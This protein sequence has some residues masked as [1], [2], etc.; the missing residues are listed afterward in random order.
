MLNCD[1]L[2]PHLLGSF[3]TVVPFDSIIE[4]KDGT[5][6][7]SMFHRYEIKDYQD[8]NGYLI[9]KCEIIVP[10]TSWKREIS[11]QMFGGRG[12]PY[13][14]KIKNGNFTLT[15]SQ[16][17]QISPRTGAILRYHCHDNYTLTGS[18]ALICDHGSWKLS[19][20]KSLASHSITHQS[21]TLAVSNHPLDYPFCSK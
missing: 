18:D 1:Y 6:Q 3:I 10:G 9:F 4:S 17:C 13:P 2:L 7:L 8:H 21:L 5:Y 11:H 15:P 20:S 12:C 19:H 14:A 16:T